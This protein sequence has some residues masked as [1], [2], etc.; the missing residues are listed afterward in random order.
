MVLFMGI[1]EKLREAREANNITLDELQETTKIQKRYLRAIEEGNYH[2]LPG[3]FY[4]RAF[5][6][7]YANAVGLNSN[8]LLEMHE[9]EL[10]SIGEKRS[11][12]QYTRLQRT[13]K[14]SS[15]SKASAFLSFL[16]TVIVIL[17]VIVIISLAWYLY[18][19]RGSDPNLNP[20]DNQQ[21]D[22]EFF[23]K[24]DGSTQPDDEDNN[25][26]DEDDSDDPEDNE[27]PDIEEPEPETELILTEAGSG[28]VPLSTFDLKTG[29]NDVKLI[30]NSTGKSWLGVAND[31]GEEFYNAFIT[32]DE[33]PFELDITD[34]E[35]IYLNIGSAQY[36]EVMFNDLLLEYPVDANE[37]VHQKIQI[38]LKQEE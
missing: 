9:D 22:N 12:V 17:L 24:K 30:I 4:A 19:Q 26:N 2:I 20:A 7:E 13:R 29:G 1:G 28:T 18:Q 5:I 10:P 36:V 33:S 27:E 34:E 38:Q 25:D 21:E 35:I 37:R 16:P 14:S 6:K 3:S 8:E 32:E 11:G 15:S 31:S 23:R